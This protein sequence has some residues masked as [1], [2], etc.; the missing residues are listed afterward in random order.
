LPGRCVRVARSC[1]I[2]CSKDW[3]LSRLSR[4][5]LKHCVSPRT[6]ESQSRMS[7]DSKS[8]TQRMRMCGPARPRCCAG[9][10]GR[11]P[12]TCAVVDLGRERQTRSRLKTWSAARIAVVLAGGSIFGLAAADGVAAWLS[13]QGLGLQWR[14][15]SPAIPIVPCA[16]LHDLSNGGDKNGAFLRPTAT[17]V[18]A[19]AAPRQ[20]TLP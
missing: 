12:W 16:V 17:S 6:E 15:G 11:Q 3:R 18:C 20:L 9:P 8:V 5:S 10:A 19:P 13:S 2:L 1:R 14:S 4:G 7:L